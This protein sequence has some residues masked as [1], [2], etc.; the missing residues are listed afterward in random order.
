LLGA[1]EPG[2]LTGVP[3]MEVG[4]GRRAPSE[5]EQEALGDLAGR[6]PLLG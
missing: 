4:T 2:G 6:F 5:T 1:P 3:L